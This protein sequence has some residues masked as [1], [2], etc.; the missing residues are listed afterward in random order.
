MIFSEQKNLYDDK[1]SKGYMEGW[2]RWKK[3]RISRL[4]SKLGLATSARVLDFG[5]GKG[6]FTNVI[7]QTIPTFHVEGTDIS[8]E[9]LKL[10]RKSCP[11]CLFFEFLTENFIEEKY[12]LVFTHHVLE[13]VEDL[14]YT[15]NQ[16]AK[17][18]CNGGKVVNVL[19]CGDKGSIEHLICTWRVDGFDSRFGNRMFF[20]YSGHLRRLTSNELIIK[21]KEKNLFIEKIFFSNVFFGSI[22]WITASDEKLIKKI[23]EIKNLKKRLYALPLLLFRFILISIYYCRWPML[24]IRKFY[25]NFNKRTKNKFYFLITVLFFFPSYIFNALI[26]WLSSFEYL[27]LKKWSGSEMYLIFTKSLKHEM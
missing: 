8:T 2:P 27:I 19:P 7:K 26:L 23:T 5:C 16:I 4:I 1:Y 17:V 14:D 12:D 25:L 20:E 13:H 18:C 6:E 9:A 10:A 21:F 24:K 3:R 15:I 11:H 22:E